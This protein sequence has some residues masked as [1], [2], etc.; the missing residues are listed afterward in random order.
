[1]VV[2]ALDWWLQLPVN[3]GLLDAERAVVRARAARL[4]R[5]AALRRTFVDCAL[6][7]A[8][9]SADDVCAY[10]SGLSEKSLPRALVSGLSRLVGGYAS[11]AREVDGPDAVLAAVRTAWERASSAC[12]STSVVVA[13]PAV[14]LA[15]GVDPLDNCVPMWSWATYS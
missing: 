1:V 4:L 14:R 2:D 12:T 8:R 6:V 5:S 15:D 3:Q 11:L 9:R 7:L 13:P 10:L